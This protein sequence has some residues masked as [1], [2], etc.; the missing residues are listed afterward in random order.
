VRGPPVG[1][2]KSRKAPASLEHVVEQVAVL[3]IVL[4]VGQVIGAHD[5]LHIRVLDA[6]F[7]GQQIAL[8][9]AA[10]VDDDIGRRAP[11]LLVV[12]GKMLDAAHNMLGLDGVDM[13]SRDF[14]GENGVFAFGLK[15]AA[16]ARLAADEIDVAA[17]IDID[18]I[19][20]QF[21]ADDGAVFGGFVR[22]PTGRAGNRR[23]Q[24]G[25]RPTPLPTPTLPSA[26]YK[27]GIPN[28]VLAGT[29]PA[30]PAEPCTHR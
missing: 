14:A 7:E 21:G 17:Q 6:N 25:G 18:S 20:G 4:A 22:V 9:A 19:I 15:R 30:A 13:R 28:L 23:G 27:A 8:S 29:H 3:A 24:R 11:A 1:H 5:R 10:L 12:K 26:R 2:D 16:I